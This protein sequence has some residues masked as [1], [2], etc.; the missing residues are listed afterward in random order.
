MILRNAGSQKE[1]PMFK[2]L[3]VDDEKA[4]R[5]GLCRLLYTIYPEDMILEAENGEQALETLELLECDIVITDIRMPGI[6]GLELLQKIRQRN[7]NTAVIILSGYEEFSYA[8]EALRYG[9]KDYLLKPVEISEVQKCLEGVRKEIIA[10]RKEDASRASMETHL[11]ETEIVYLEYLMQHFVCR[12]NFDK[13]E[14]IREILPIEQP[15]YL[16]LCEV[17]VENGKALNIPEFRMAIKS[18]IAASSYSFSCEQKN[19]FAILV[20]DC[21]KG[22]RSFFNH[23]ESLLQKRLSGC[24]F[25]FYIS[26]CHKNMLEEAPAAYQE[27]QTLWKYRF[28]E[29]GSYCD[30]DLQKDRLE[31]ALPDFSSLAAKIA[32]NIKQNHIFHAFQLIKDPLTELTQ[33][34][35]PD[36]ERLRRGIMLV[37]FQSVKILEP[38][39]SEEARSETDETLN[40]IYQSKTVSALLR[41]LYSYL[42][43]LGKDVNYQKE[44]KGTHVMEHCCEYLQKHYMEEITLETVADKYYFNP[45]YFST[46]FKNYTGSSFSSYLTGLRMKKAKEFLSSTDEKV[47]EIAS[48]AGYRDANY[49]IRAFKKYYGY[50]PDEYRRMKAKD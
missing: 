16:F 4:Q 15:G 29:T 30:Y 8:K 10:H 2:I 48:K 38:M 46:L 3:I 42:L 50:T 26:S 43:E 49:F 6:N 36:P 14:K 19:L 13:K 1:I 5:D 34:R 45:S 47:K 9:A 25:A 39:L 35:M 18:C 21:A 31:G 7:Q 11:Q 40:R 33:K 37:L 28:Y 24:S 44:V 20:L 41:F 17:K 12:Q 23:M 27:A 22:D 32:E